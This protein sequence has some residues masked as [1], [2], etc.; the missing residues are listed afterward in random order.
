MVSCFCILGAIH[1]H[2]ESKKRAYRDD[3]SDKTSQKRRSCAL[4]HRVGS[5]E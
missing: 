5:A 3:K 2:F 1:R 4:K